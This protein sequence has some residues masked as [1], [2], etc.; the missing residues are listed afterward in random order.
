MLHKQIYEAEMCRVNEL[1]YKLSCFILI[2][3]AKVNTSSLQQIYE[4]WPEVTNHL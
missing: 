3:K 4:F 1:P 2:G